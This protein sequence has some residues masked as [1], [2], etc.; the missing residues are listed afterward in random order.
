MKLAIMQP[1]FFPYI[2]Y[3]QLINVVDKFVVYDNIQYTKKGWI[4]RNR[5][6]RNKKD[7]IFTIPIKKDSDFLNVTE[8][9]ISDVYNRDKLIFQLK[10]AYQ[11]APFFK[12]NITIIEEIIQYKSSNLFEYIHYSILKINNFLDIDTE[13]ITSSRM[14]INHDLKSQDKVIAICKSLDTS[15]YIN[16]IGGVNLY[17]K[18]DFLNHNIN[19]LFLEPKEIQYNQFNNNFISNLSIIDVMMFNNKEHIK[20]L[21]HKFVLL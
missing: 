16:P 11:K 9:S 17:N 7:T 12:E 4:N 20:E 15:V 13:V 21:L 6:L 18:I 3:F 1:Y 8:R 5:F 14:D 10:M 19:L 2:G